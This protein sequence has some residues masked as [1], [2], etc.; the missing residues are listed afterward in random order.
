M[1]GP[2]HATRIPVAEGGSLR[3]RLSASADRLALEAS[4]CPY[5]FT[6]ALLG[7]NLAL[8]AC[9]AIAGQELFADRVELFRELMPGT[10]L[11]AALLLFVAAAAWAVHV[12]AEPQGRLAGFWALSAIVFTLFAIHEL[13]Q[14]T[15]FLM[16]FLADRG[17][18]SPGFFNDLDA[19]FLTVLLVIAVALLLRYAGALLAHR[20]AIALLAAGVLIGAASEALDAL[21]TPSA[22]ESV[23]EESLK[24]VA[25]PFLIGGYLVALRDVTRGR[26]V[27]T[28][29]PGT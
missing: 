16:H 20:S 7:L 25:E 2:G 14:P 23:A 9:F 22:W 8:V 28:S 17:V 3:Q 1:S 21:V 29:Q 26:G 19:F 11:S 6:I 18:A 12:R 4:A 10:W 15:V 24:L 13:T 5:L 27:A